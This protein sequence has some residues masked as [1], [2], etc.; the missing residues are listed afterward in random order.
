M[1]L[2]CSVNSFSS[3]LPGNCNCCLC[4][5]CTLNCENWNA[6]AFTGIRENMLKYDKCISYLSV[7]KSSFQLFMCKSLLKES[8]DD[9]F[10]LSSY[11]SGW[12]CHWAGTRGQFLV[13]IFTTQYL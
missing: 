12:E 1:I 8:K 11:T 6:V 4:L 2:I 7:I 5:F 9:D 13:L 10:P 3:R